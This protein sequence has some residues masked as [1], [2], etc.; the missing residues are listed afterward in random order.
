MAVRVTADVIDRNLHMGANGLFLDDPRVPPTNKRAERALRLSVVLRKITIGHRRLGTEN[1]ASSQQHSSSA[2]IRAAGYDLRPR[3]L[4]V[5]L[6]LP[7]LFGDRNK[8]PCR[9]ECPRDED[10][11]IMVPPKKNC[12]DHCWDLMSLSAYWPD[13]TC[14]LRSKTKMP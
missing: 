13:Q 14:K 1:L 2:E 3:D 9:F 11:T 12:Y 10:Q 6:L 4:T 7:R 5:T 8:V